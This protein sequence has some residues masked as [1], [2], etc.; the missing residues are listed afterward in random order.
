[1]HMVVQISLFSCC[2]CKSITRFIETKN[3]RAVDGSSEQDGRSSIEDERRP[4]IA[5]SAGNGGDLL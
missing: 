5:T 3:P 2:A 1:M 4:E